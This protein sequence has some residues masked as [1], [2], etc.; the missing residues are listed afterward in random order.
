VILSS[1]GLVAVMYGVVQAGSN[2]WGSLNAI[3]PA[4]VALWPSRLRALGAPPDRAAGRA[5][6]RRFVVFGSRS[7]TGASFSVPS[8]YSGSLASCSPCRSTSRDHGFSTH[9]VRGC[10]CWL[11]SGA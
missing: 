9:R 1:A 8:A 11:S 2:G 10:A 4:L 5:A 3:L 7:F 6:A